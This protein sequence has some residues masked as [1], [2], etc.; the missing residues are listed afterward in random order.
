MAYFPALQ[1]PATLP[2]PAYGV[3]VIRDWLAANQ[4]RA[5][6]AFGLT[7]GAEPWMQVELA[8]LFDNMVQ[9]A[10][11]P[12]H[13][14]GFWTVSRERTDILH[15]DEFYKQR[16]IDVYMTS[17]ALVAGR[18]IGIELKYHRPGQ[19]P[20]QFGEELKKD[21]E[22]IADG[23]LAGNINLYAVGITY[24][25]VHTNVNKS[26]QAENEVARQFPPTAGAANRVYYTQV[27][28]GNGGHFNIIWVCLYDH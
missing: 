25:P 28:D 3:L 4:V 13:A 22:R 20:D 7:G 21:M 27:A 1:D 10:A 15:K 19:T 5:R 26:Y 12:V 6:R 9:P 14:G 17:P 18:D 16:K 24:D 8:L 11:L 2:S 23:S